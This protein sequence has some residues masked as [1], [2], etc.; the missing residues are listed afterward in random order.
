MEKTARALLIAMSYLELW[1]DD[2]I[3][4]D[5]ALG[6]LESISAELQNATQEEIEIITNVANK[7][8]D[9]TAN[10]DEKEFYEEFVENYGLNE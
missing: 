7:L 9:A 8:A 5:I 1:D 4:P 6:A 3:D 10:E 2:V